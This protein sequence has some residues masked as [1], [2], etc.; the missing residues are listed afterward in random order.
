[1]G[2]A[3]DMQLGYWQ[4]Y[5]TCWYCYL[6][7]VADTQFVRWCCYLAFEG[8]GLLTYCYCQ[9]H[10]AGRLLACLDG[11]D[12]QCVPLPVCGELL[13][14]SSVALAVTE[15]LH[16]GVGKAA[17]LPGKEMPLGWPARVVCSLPVGLAL[18]GWSAGGTVP[19]GGVC[20]A[21][22]QPPSA[23]CHWVDM[24]GADRG[25]CQWFATNDCPVCTERH[26]MAVIPTD[27][28]SFL[29]CSMPTLDPGVDTVELW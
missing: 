7:H 11:V 2:F 18:G 13:G 26:L 20:L 28:V 6:V 24:S 21:V 27:V 14:K 3:P 17:V 8:D 23:L 4:C 15:G 9:V 29:W 22:V 12:S 25:S 16:P 1:M 5:L 10:V 19:A